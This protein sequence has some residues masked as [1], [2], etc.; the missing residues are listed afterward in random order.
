ME[1]E[2]LPLKDLF[3][4]LP[5]ANIYPLGSALQRKGGKGVLKKGK[6]EE[7]RYQIFTFIY[8]THIQYV[9]M[10]LLSLQGIIYLEAFSA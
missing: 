5:T 7:K 1:R 4:T 9:H 2:S 6:S 3:T 10:Y 8:S